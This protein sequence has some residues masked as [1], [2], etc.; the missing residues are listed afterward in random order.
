[1]CQVVTALQETVNGN[2]AE[3]IAA[4][5]S[6]EK[7]HVLVGRQARAFYRFIIP[8]R[9]YIH[10]KTMPTE[11]NGVGLPATWFAL[12]NSRQLP[13]GK[14]QT[15][16]AGTAHSVFGDSCRCEIVRF[17]ARRPSTCAAV[18]NG[19]TQGGESPAPPD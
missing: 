18:T 13:I 5:C 9:E 15:A 7:S 1:M 3:T 17:V 19:A 16:I 10:Q 12:K 8:I 4:P 6:R 14:M 2:D 11:R